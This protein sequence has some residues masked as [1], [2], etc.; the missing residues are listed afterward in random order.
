MERA[1]SRLHGEIL[2]TRAREVKDENARFRRSQ[3][4]KNS[5]G[6]MQK[7]SSIDYSEAHL[8]GEI[9][10]MG[11]KVFDEL[12]NPNPLYENNIADSPAFGLGDCFL[13]INE[14]LT[15]SFIMSQPIPV[16]DSMTLVV[17]STISP[18]TSSEKVTLDKRQFIST[19]LHWLKDAEILE[20]CDLSLKHFASSKEM[21][22]VESSCRS[23]NKSSLFKAI[24]SCLKSN[25]KLCNAYRDTFFLEMLSSSID[26]FTASSETLTI[27]SDMI[28]IIAEPDKTSIR[29]ID[30]KEVSNKRR[31]F[32]DDPLLST[33]TEAIRSSQLLIGSTPTDPKF[34]D[35]FGVSSNS[36]SKTSSSSSTVSSSNSFSDAT[37]YDKLAHIR[38]NILRVCRVLISEPGKVLPST[39]IIESIKKDLRREVEHSKKMD[40]DWKTKSKQAADKLAS[41]Q[42]A[43]SSSSTSSSS[44]ST[45]STA[46]FVVT[47]EMKPPPPVDHSV[48]TML[49][50]ILNTTTAYA[51]T[52]PTSNDDNVTKNASIVQ[53]NQVLSL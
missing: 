20:Q 29:N 16:T 43:Y 19:A 10:K 48:L 46:P 31:L 45:T 50:D 12:V 37:S 27:I 28:A 4:T 32:L 39:L 18:I 38:V 17:D 7:P 42:Q 53:R 33:I 26:L 25:P 40:E 49:L 41:A 15:P 2:P 34:Y 9:L 22:D 47:D 1:R 23:W 6:F 8:C 24:I 35:A 44:S 30:T 36:S 11:A 52:A 13:R 51:I 14:Q 5:D 3:E 21:D